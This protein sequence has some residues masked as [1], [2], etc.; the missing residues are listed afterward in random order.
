VPASVG[1]KTI[2]TGQKILL[3][4]GQM[5][6]L[7]ETEVPTVLAT[8]LGNPLIHNFGSAPSEKK[9]QL[10]ASGPKVSKDLRDFEDKKMADKVCKMCW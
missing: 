6:P 9:N 10:C 2:V 1:K 7:D 8:N 3:F 4:A 5:A